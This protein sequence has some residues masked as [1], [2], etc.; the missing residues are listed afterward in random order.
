M[1]DQA[2]LKGKNILITG[3]AGFIGSNL[4]EYFLSLGGNVTCL[5]N[6]STGFYKNIASFVK[7]E[8]FT[9]IEVDIRDL[10]ACL[11]ACENQDYVRSNH[12]KQR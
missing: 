4:C 5:D 9:F 6:L 3:G 10:N 8:N 12:H 2:I 7:L 11:E 1:K